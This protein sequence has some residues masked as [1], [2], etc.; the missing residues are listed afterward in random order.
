MITLKRLVSAFVL[1]LIVPLCV[2]YSKND[3]GILNYDQDPVRYFSRD[4][5]RFETMF[6]TRWIDLNYHT[7]HGDNV[8]HYAALKGDLDWVKRIVEMGAD[9]NEADNNGR[10]PLLFA[11]I[12]G[13]LALVE[14]LAQQGADVN[15]KD[16]DK[17]T[18]LHFAA[19]VGALDLVKWLVEKGLDVNA[20]DNDIGK[21]AVLLYAVESDSLELVQW[22]VQHG[23]DVKVTDYYGQTALQYAVKKSSLEMIQWLVKQGLDVNVTDSHGSTLLH[24]ASQ[25]ASLEIVQWFLEQG[26]D[27]NAKDSLGHTPIFYTARSNFPEQVEWMVERGAD[28]NA[29]D[30]I[31][32]SVFYY[33][34]EN[35]HLTLKEKQ[36]LFLWLDEHGADLKKNGA[37]ALFQAALLGNLELVK[38]LVEQGVDVNSVFPDHK[39]ALHFAARGGNLDLALWLIEQGV[40]VNAEADG[41]EAALTLACDCDK[42]VFDKNS[43]KMVQLLVEHGA[44]ANPNLGKKLCPY[45]YELW[46]KQ[47]K[48]RTGVNF[49]LIRYLMFHDPVFISAVTVIL[50][51][52]IL[53]LLYFVL[54]KRAKKNEQIETA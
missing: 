38:W 48:S 34:C 17:K 32:L 9:V 28:V 33:I 12:K 45:W 46:K 7:S 3:D 53:A 24:Y 13:K 27:I 19:E 20:K 36:N 30:K 11:A 1:F 37:D 44:I 15:V 43:L 50:L 51:T 49:P 47:S 5:E 23:A 16:P 29:K 40:D 6:R 8:L 31:G 42:I 39:T 4:I 22:L 14:Y 2:C 35:F 21:K 25:R 18:A 41:G 54:I 10:T 26:L 52:A